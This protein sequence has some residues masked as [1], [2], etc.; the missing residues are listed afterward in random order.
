[1]SGRMMRVLWKASIYLALGLVA[2][3]S[4]EV[5]SENSDQ[6]SAPLRKALAEAHKPHPPQRVIGGQE[7]TIESN[8]WQV[9]I[10]A[11][12]ESDNRLAQYCGGSIIARRWVLTAAHC[13]DEG[14]KEAQISI[15][16]GTASLLN[17]GSRIAVVKILLNPNWNNNHDSD[18]ALLHVASDLGGQAIDALDANETGLVSGLT[19]RVSG[20]GKVNWEDR[21]GTIVL[22]DVE[23]PYIP[24]AVCDK[25][26]FYDGRITNNMIC[27]GE[28]DKDTCQADSG[29]PASGVVNGQRRL[30]GVV[31]WGD[32]CGQVNRPGVYTRVSKFRDW[33]STASAGEVGW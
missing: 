30:V 32:G 13:V 10:V 22:H 6:G 33:V 1:M 2:S 28:A 18:L 29:G 7:A 17:G 26:A 11:A 16:T 5:A 20:W 12:A 4:S 9:A 27:A 14:T 25:P 24:N 21:V 15:L 19:V 23:V 8:P 3:G 31:S